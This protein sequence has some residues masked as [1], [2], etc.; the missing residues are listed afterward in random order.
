M[1]TDTDSIRYLQFLTLP[2]P[3]FTFEYHTDTDTNFA[4]NTD[5]TDN[6]SIPTSAE[7][8]R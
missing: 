4:K 7:W 2:I 6:R 1:F 8:L 5:Y 3:V